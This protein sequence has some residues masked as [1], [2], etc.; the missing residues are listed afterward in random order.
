MHRRRTVS[1]V[2]IAGAMALA[3]GAFAR[4]IPW[5]WR[6]AQLLYWQRQCVRYTFSPQ[7]L[8]LTIPVSTTPAVIAPP[9][10][11]LYTLMSHPGMRSDGTVFLHELVSPAGHRRLV[12]VGM[13]LAWNHHFFSCGTRVIA[14][15]NLSS[16][17]KEIIAGAAV[18][19]FANI[20]R[21]IR[22][23]GGVADPSDPSHFTFAVEDGSDHDEMNGWLLDDDLVRL[24][25]HQNA[26][27]QPVP[28]SPAS[29]P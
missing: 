11:A 7:Q 1:R 4:Q 5:L 10:Q 22:V 17:P 29:S 14:L 21:P 28:V 9:W 12:A 13:N 3:L 27:T 19:E 16:D 24:E 20:P 23:F 2:L 18:E 26:S 15:G 6:H 25:F 8:I